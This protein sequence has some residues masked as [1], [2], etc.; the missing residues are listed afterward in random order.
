M[1][2]GRFVAS[3]QKAVLP[4]SRGRQALR[5]FSVTSVRR[6]VLDGSN[7]GLSRYLNVLMLRVTLK[8][9]SGVEVVRFQ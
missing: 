7:M 6:R 9:R 3:H 5:S 1:Q 4:V 8:Y 2:I